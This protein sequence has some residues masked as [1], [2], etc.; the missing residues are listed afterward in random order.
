MP[1][2]VCFLALYFLP[3]VIGYQKGKENIAAIFLVNLV[4]GWLFGLGWFIALVWSVTN[5]GCRRQN[6]EVARP[7]LTAYVGG[8][9]VWFALLIMVVAS[10]AVIAGLA[11]CLRTLTAES[12]KT[13]SGGSTYQLGTDSTSSSHDDRTVSNVGG[14][15][16]RNYGRAGVIDTGGSNRNLERLSSLEHSLAL[17]QNQQANSNTENNQLKERV[18]DKDIEIQQLRELLSDTRVKSEQNIS[19]ANAESQR[20]T[21]Q[22]N[23][24]VR[25]SDRQRVELARLSNNL[26]VSEE[27]AGFK[28]KDVDQ[29]VKALALA[30][31]KAEQFNS[32]LPE[33]S[34]A[35]K[36]EQ[37]GLPA[38]LWPNVANF[39]PSAYKQ[40]V[41]KRLS[42]ASS[43]RVIFSDEDGP[44]QKCHFVIEKD[45]RPTNILL[46]SAVQDEASKKRFVRFIEA[47]GPF[48]PL[49]SSDLENIQVAAQ[50]TQAQGQRPNITLLQIEARGNKL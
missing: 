20:L 22:L 37:A 9:V 33:Q 27:L 41:E 15:N 31:S 3:S 19:A 42:K 5:N 21:A 35:V 18:A 45:G 24:A 26:R 6:K 17:A 30:K 25:L 11:G 43:D 44:V 29:L 36:Q 48:R 34:L 49:V 47:A 38:V 10:Q 50:I 16:G 32:P 23:E 1:A 28:S 8:L 4:L 13:R 40:D 14:E 7:L 39:S 2:L 12:P 46:S